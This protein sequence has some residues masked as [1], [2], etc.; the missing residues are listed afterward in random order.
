MGDVSGVQH[1]LDKGAELHAHRGAA[2][3]AAAE[4]GHAAVVS[5]LLLRGAC[6]RYNGVDNGALRLSAA[7]GHT[8]TVEVLLQRRT[9]TREVLA[10]ACIVAAEGGHCDVVQLLLERGAQGSM[11]MAGGVIGA[12]LIKA[13]KAGH[14]DTV[15][16]LLN[17]GDTLWGGWG[18]A[19]QGDNSALYFAA[20][21]GHK[22]IIRQLLN[23]GFAPNPAWNIALHV[24]IKTAT[25]SSRLADGV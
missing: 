14:A 13:A 10:C 24:M 8:Q 2:L 4:H 25:M 12:A 15:S 23:R 1:L 11:V 5:L 7:S 19:V 20:K 3:R 6:T 21:A 16:L 18:Q 17:K 9:L 22:A